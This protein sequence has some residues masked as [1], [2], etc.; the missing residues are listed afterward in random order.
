MVCLLSGCGQ[1][2][3]MIENEDYKTYKDND[4]DDV[5]SNKHKV[6]EKKTKIP[7]DTATIK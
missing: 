7:F 5:K 1:S 3:N 4:D 2:K 6:I